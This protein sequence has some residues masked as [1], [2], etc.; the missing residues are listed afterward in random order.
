MPRSDSARGSVMPRAP[1]SRRVR[2]GGAEMSGASCLRGVSRPS[3]SDRDHAAEED[4]EQKE[5]EADQVQHEA[6]GAD[7]AAE[8]KALHEQ[9]GAADERDPGEP[10][11]QHSA[12]DDE[13]PGGDQ[14]DAAEDVSDA[15]ERERQQ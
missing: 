3:A 13:E 5:H 4:E 1:L 2:S 6:V 15:V 7:D 8:A 11:R 10:A 9:Q 12:L 14:E